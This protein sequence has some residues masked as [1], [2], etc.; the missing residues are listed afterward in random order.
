ML[1]EFVRFIR[2]N[3]RSLFRKKTA[4]ERIISEKM[5]IREEVK[6]AKR[7][8]TDEYIDEQ[9]FVVFGK[10]EVMPEFI[11][12]K[13]LMLYWSMKDELPTHN[14]IRKWS[15][16][17]TILLPVVKGSH[18]TIKPYSANDEMEKNS[19][20][21]MEPQSTKEYLDK[22]DLVIIPGVA[23]D[24]NRRRLGR[25]KGY[26]D[27]YFK[28]KKFPKWGIC[29]DFQLYHNIP[30]AAFDVRMDKI[31]TASETIS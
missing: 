24:K 13:I 10:I 1:F 31:I 26:Y 7:K 6:A 16:T 23:F 3:S 4:E 15:K 22:V 12:A 20:G 5:I 28:H 8:M 30:S 9:A 27:R 17:K 19:L 25:G 2:Q 18:M 11:N 21:V 14:F 29:F